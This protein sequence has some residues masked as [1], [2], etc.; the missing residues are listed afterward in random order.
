MIWLQ[1]NLKVALGVIG[2]AAIALFFILSGESG[3]E[4][5]IN[6]RLDDLCELVSY[7]Q[8]APQLAQI[9]TTKKLSGYFT[10]KPYLIAWPGQAAITDQNAVSGMFM[11]LLKYASEAE[12]SLGSRQMTLQN[13]T[14]A[15]VTANVTAKAKVNG[16]TER[17][18]GRY[19]IE[20]EE[21]DGNWLISSA[22]PIN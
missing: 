17:H 22:Q 3:P 16:E 11:Y 15:I 2:L 10:E 13:E 18:S 1:Q 14:S 12:V 9:T 5:A 20:L 6:S 8:R 4:G 19:R 21:V 7:E